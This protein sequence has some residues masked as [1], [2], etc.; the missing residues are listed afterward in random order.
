MPWLAAYAAFPHHRKAMLWASL[1][2][3]PFGLTEPLF[4]PAYWSPPSLF[5][6]ARTTGFDIKSLIFTFGIGGIGP[7]LYNLLTGRA[8]E[9]V[10]A[11]ERRLARHKLHHWALATPFIAFP[12]LYPFP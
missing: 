3:P 5:D 8:L 6:L 10:P 1:F 7:V 2:S 4:V 9:D 12:I 11:A